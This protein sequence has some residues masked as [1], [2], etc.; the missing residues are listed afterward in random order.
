MCWCLHL[1]RPLPDSLYPL[2]ACL[3]IAPSLEDLSWPAWFV[4]LHCIAA[5]MDSCSNTR[6]LR[7]CLSV[8]GWRDGTESRRRRRGRRAGTGGNARIR[9]DGRQIIA[10]ARQRGDYDRLRV[11]LYAWRRSIFLSSTNNCCSCLMLNH[12]L[13]PL[14]Q[15][16]SV[17]IDPLN[18]SMN[19]QH[20]I[21]PCPPFCPCVLSTDVKPSPSSKNSP[22]LSCTTLLLHPPLSPRTIIRSPLTP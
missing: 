5:R 21:P 6:P 4:Q 19:P 13:F 12:S 9:I 3:V 11:S 22:P 18:F 10:A 2:S 20:S 1:H 7:G 14:L 16:L 8:C 15:N 17:F